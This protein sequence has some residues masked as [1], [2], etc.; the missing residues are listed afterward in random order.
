MIAGQAAL[1]LTPAQ[2]KQRQDIA[3]RKTIQSRISTGSASL[4]IGGLGLV[5]ASALARKRPGLMRVKGDPRAVSRKIK[6]KGYT[7][8]ITSTGVGSGSGLYFA[9][10][11]RREAKMDNQSLVEKPKMSALSKAARRSVAVQPGSPG[12]DES[13]WRRKDSW[14]PHV[15]QNAKSVYDGPLLPSRRRADADRAFGTAML[16]AGAM[17]VAGGMVP[18][19]TGIRRSNI[20]L[21]LAGIAAEGGSV[22]AARA[23]SERFR[24]ASRREEASRKI[25]ARGHQRRLAAPPQYASVDKGFVSSGLVRSGGRIKVRAPFFRRPVLKPKG[26]W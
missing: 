7:L 17:G 20:P 14:R 2:I 13:R 9:G 3:H 23:G 1:P 4:G 8:G 25:R 24:S 19:A 18:I 22:I 15:S 11:Q 26:S 21:T 10:T 6:D 16:G 5:A 12:W